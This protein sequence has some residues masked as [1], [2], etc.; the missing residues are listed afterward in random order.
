MERK[1]RTQLRRDARNKNKSIGLARNQQQHRNK[2]VY[3]NF[4]KPN[5]APLKPAR[6][7]SFI[8]QIK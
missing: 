5:F 4:A 8:R 3:I 1:E 7:P 6:A 2:S